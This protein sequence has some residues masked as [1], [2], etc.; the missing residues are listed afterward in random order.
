[1]KTLNYLEPWPKSDKTEYKQDK[2]QILFLA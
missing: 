2:S 1:M